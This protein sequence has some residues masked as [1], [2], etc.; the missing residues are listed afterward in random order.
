M[1]IGRLLRLAIKVA[2]GLVL[3]WVAAIL[4]LGLLYS[5]VPPISTLMLG[6]WLTL[7]PVARGSVSLATVSPSLPIAVITSEDQRFCQHWGIDFD[8][9]RQVVEN[10]DEDGP[11]RGASTVPMQVAKNLFLWPGRS[12]IRKGLELPI[13]L[14]LDLIW[15]KRRMMEIY[16]S[17]AE[18]GDG[19]FGVAA[20]AQ[21][22]FGKPA[23]DL[24][25]REAALLVAALP[26]PIERNAGRPSARHRAMANRLMGRMDPALAACLRS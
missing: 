2:L 12:Y 3:A 26:N 7:Q 13:A 14:Y 24:S 20:A 23:G 21:K 1:A 18:W 25:R 8:A 11:N 10:A 17:V 15:S 5:V 9:L 16:L 19:I 4:V 22:H 6:R